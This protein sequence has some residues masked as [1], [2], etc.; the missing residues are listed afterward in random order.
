MGQISLGGLLMKR[1]LNYPGSKWSMADKI[2]NL[3]P[4]HETYVEPFFGSGAVFFNKPKVK[5]ET[6]NDMDG[7]LVNFFRVCRDNPEEL[8]KAIKLTPHSREEYQMS[9][10]QADDSIED[11]RRLMVRCWQAIG[12]K[13]SDITGWR[14]L[15]ESNGPDT[16]REWDLVWQRI[17]DVAFRLK[18]AQIDRQDAVKLLGRYNRKSV[19]TYVDPPYLLQTRSKRLYQHEYNNED[20]VEFLELL[21]DFQGDVLLSGYDSV[22]YDEHLQGWNK[23]YFDSTAEV[24]AKRVEVLWLNYDPPAQLKLFD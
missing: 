8:I 3:M 18:G 19:L 11:A 15:I 1:I 7:R 14:S 10:E 4:A 23:L 16:N 24:G 9:Y 22:L 21:A 5:V 2:I 12:A 13:T 20:H 6:I 17:E